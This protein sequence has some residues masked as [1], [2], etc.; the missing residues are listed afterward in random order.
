M[1]VT[2]DVIVDL[3]PLVESGEA[4][5]DTRELVERFLAAN[6]ELKALVTRA[7]SVAKEIP[8]PSPSTTT[9]DAVALTRIVKTVRRRTTLLAFAVLLTFWPLSFTADFSGHGPEIT[10]LYSGRVGDVAGI[11]SGAAVL[12]W[13]YFRQRKIARTLGV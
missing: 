1:N 5:A 3:L 8:R 10:F 4:S 12:W 6:P 9:E 7:A 2:R 13:N 11:W